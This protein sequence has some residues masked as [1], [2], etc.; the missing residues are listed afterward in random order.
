MVLLGHRGDVQ[1]IPPEKHVPPKG[2]FE[3][4]MLPSNHLRMVEFFQFIIPWTPKSM[5]I[6]RKGWKKR[7]IWFGTCFCVR[8][9]FLLEQLHSIFQSCSWCRTS[10]LRITIQTVVIHCTPTWLCLFFWVWGKTLAQV[11]ETLHEGL[12]VEL[13]LRYQYKPKLPFVLCTEG[14]HV[15][16]WQPPSLL[17]IRFVWRHFVAFQVPWPGAG[18]VTEIGSKVGKINGADLA[19]EIFW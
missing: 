16:S 14:F 9:A 3:K 1:N 2:P 8:F 18:V 13:L 7:R 15:C 11:S 19:L 10:D 4:E 12:C 17:L 6:W 5:E